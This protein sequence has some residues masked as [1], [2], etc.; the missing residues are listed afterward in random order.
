MQVTVK[1]DASYSLSFDGRR[2][3]GSVIAGPQD[4]D[5]DLALCLL[6]NGIAEAGE[7]R[8]PLVEDVTPGGSRAVATAESPEPAS[9]NPPA[10]NASASQ[11]VNA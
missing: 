2:H 6:A 10:A 7:V 8:T 4:V 11:E 9:T 3:E 5:D 1:Q